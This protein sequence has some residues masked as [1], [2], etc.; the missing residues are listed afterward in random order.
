VDHLSISAGYVKKAEVTTTS[1]H[2]MAEVA[3]KKMYEAKSK[4]YGR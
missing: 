3:D 2:E 1:V 4:F